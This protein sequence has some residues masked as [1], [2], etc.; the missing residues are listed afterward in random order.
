MAF[1]VVERQKEKDVLTPEDSRRV[2]DRMIEAIERIENKAILR[3]AE[4]DAKI[5]YEGSIQKAIEKGCKAGVLAS[6]RERR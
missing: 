5:R 3:I 4:F 2:A 1:Y 6:E